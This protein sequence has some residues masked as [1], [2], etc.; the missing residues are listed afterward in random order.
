[1]STVKGYD[2][3]TNGQTK[4]V[5]S[6][7][8]GVEVALAF[9]RGEFILTKVAVGVAS[10]ILGCTVN[11]FLPAT[12]EFLAKEKFVVN[13]FEDVGVGV[14][15]ID[16]EF[17]GNNPPGVEVKIANIDE[18]FSTWFLAGGGK[19][20]P[21]QPEHWVRYLKIKK[22]S[23]DTSFIA[24]LGGEEQVETLLSDLWGLLKKQ[25]QGGKGALLSDGHANIFYVR[26]CQGIIRT[27]YAGWHGDGWHIH[28]FSVEFPS[29]WCIDDRLFSRN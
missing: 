26:D 18:A 28:A 15:A 20:E 9:L 6:K 8:G 25:P 19:I 4:A 29:G 24:D 17:V 22:N 12:T 5:I 16:G 11:V 13:T 10:A 3:M 2:D 27:V 23:L 1:M 21:A 14:I 7:M